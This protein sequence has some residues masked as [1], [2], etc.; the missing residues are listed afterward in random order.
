MN[1]PQPAEPQPVPTRPATTLQAQAEPK[2]TP[3]KEA[4]RVAK[5]VVTPRKANDDAFERFLES[6]K[7]RG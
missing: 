3:D 7:R 6:E 4:E 5:V 2:P 1:K